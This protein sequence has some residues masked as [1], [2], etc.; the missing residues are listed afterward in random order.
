MR[1]KQKRLRGLIIAGI[2][3][4][5]A[6]LGIWFLSPG[7]W[8]SETMVVV[9]S[10]WSLFLIIAWLSRS[11]KWGFKLSIWIVLLGLLHRAGILDPILFGVW[12]AILGLICLFN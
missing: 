11:K 4:L 12:L 10:W 5:L 7:M 9:L 6:G 1:D 3:L 8:W 2:S